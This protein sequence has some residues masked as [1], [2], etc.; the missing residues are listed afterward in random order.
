MPQQCT[1]LN[2]FVVIIL[3]GKKIKE[4]T[5]SLLSHLFFTASTETE[6]Y[7]QQFLTSKSLDDILK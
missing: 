2:Y 4:P 3:R 7:F 1:K 5:K 6:S